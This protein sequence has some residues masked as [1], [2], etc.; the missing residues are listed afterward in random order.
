MLV[1]PRRAGT[2]SLR[3]LTRSSRR[4]TRNNTCSC[5]DTLKSYKQASSSAGRLASCLARLSISRQQARLTR[6]STSLR[7]AVARQLQRCWPLPVLAWRAR[8]WQAS[9]LAAWL[10]GCSAGPRASWRQAKTGSANRYG[11]HRLLA[12]SRRTVESNSN[13]LTAGGLGLRA[14]K[15]AHLASEAGAAT[16]APSGLAN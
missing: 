5:V 1:Y 9:E 15:R 3:T 12:A 11:R 6:C 2:R 13:W 8:I 14:G 4:Q 10:F 16:S 7:F